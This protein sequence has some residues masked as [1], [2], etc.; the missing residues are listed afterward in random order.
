MSLSNPK[1]K[2]PVSSWL[3]WSGSKGKFKMYDK[4]KK[5]NVFFE[6]TI[7][8]IVLDELTTIK[9]FS[10]QA[11]SG[12]YSNEIKNLSKDILDVRI[13]N[14]KHIVSGLYAGIKG[15]LEGGKFAKSVYAAMIQVTKE[16]TT[17]EM[18]N[19]SLVGS[20]LGAWF[21]ARIDTDSGKVIEL[22]PSADKLKNG[23]TIYYAPKIKINVVR[24]DILEKCKSMDVRL[25]EYLS[26][27]LDKEANKV[28]DNNANEFSDITDIPDDNLPY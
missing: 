9:G 28:I 7:Y 2:H 11:Q 20:A 22:H 4:E 27:Y 16:E 25:Q 12:I 13:H 3:E 5:E 14:G 6:K 18:I 19:I 24:E 15:K 26:H 1:V 10:K 21:D 8:I 23:S 17:V